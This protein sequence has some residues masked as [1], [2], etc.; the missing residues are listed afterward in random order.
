M[1]KND[2]RWSAAEM[3]AVKS[4]EPKTSAMRDIEKIDI[5][6]VSSDDPSGKPLTCKFSLHYSFIK[7]SN[8]NSQTPKNILYIPGG[9]GTIVELEDVDPDKDR[10]GV[11]A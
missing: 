2:S 6:D 5:A 4:R 1:Q 9:P 11:N 3:G 10:G 7:P 8:P